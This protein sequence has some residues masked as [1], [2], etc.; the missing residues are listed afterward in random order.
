[1]NYALG[2]SFK[3]VGITY[4]FDNTTINTFSD[5]SRNLFQTLNFRNISGPNAL[6]GIITSSVTPT[7]GFSTI[8]SPIRPH[9]GKSFFLSTE[10]AGLGGNV[11][12]YRPLALYTQW[13]PTDHQNT[14]GMR[15]QG[16]FIGGFGGRE[17][18][19]YQRFYMGGESDLRGFDIRTVSPYVFVSTVQNFP[20]T[21]PDG[22]PV[23]VDPTNPRRGNVQVPIPVNNI[24][25]PGGDTQFISNFEYRIKVVGPVVVAP[26]AD[27]GMDFV[28][29]P[30]QLRIAPDAVTQLN[31]TIFGCPSIGADFQCTGGVPSPVSGNLTP[32]PGTNYVPRMSTGLE[33]QVLLPIVQQPFR[34]YY[35]YNPLTLNTLVK[36]PSPIVRSMFPPGAAG[37]FTFQ[38]AIASLAPDF[39]LTEP[40]KTFRF[41]I[42]T[43]F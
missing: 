25:L 13:I 3:R 15:F 4:S 39:R 32:V 36:S 34:I 8:D 42:S 9:K 31:S 38:Q 14:F 23:L 5:A 28:T 29:L 24:T 7:F 20:L 37:D 30:S 10:V 26:F 16:S 41:T 17:A 19:P 35:A 40:K 33:L 1:L 27:F 6:K 12:F 2:H 11:N 21:N 18:P 43:T 22:T